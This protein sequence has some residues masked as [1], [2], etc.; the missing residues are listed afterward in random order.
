VTIAESLQDLQRRRD[1]LAEIKELE[2]PSADD[3][4][5]LRTHRAKFDLVEPRARCA[6]VESVSRFSPLV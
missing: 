3:R 2:M 1:L 5:A 4:E 6:A